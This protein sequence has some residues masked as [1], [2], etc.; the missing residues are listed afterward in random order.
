MRQQN[1][2]THNMKISRRAERNR[3]RVEEYRRAQIAKMQMLENQRYT[4][5]Q[6]QDPR[7]P[8]QPVPQMRH[9]NPRLPVPQ[10][11]AQ[12]M[13]AARFSVPQMEAPRLDISHAANDVHINSL[14][15]LAVSTAN[16]NV[17]DPALTKKLMVCLFVLLPRGCK[18]N[19]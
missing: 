12:P 14:S 10:M 11:H 7:L 9:P 13:Q 6:M 16:L 8:I 2:N 17:T 18:K 3:R 15:D 1:P 4:I 19:T 5:P